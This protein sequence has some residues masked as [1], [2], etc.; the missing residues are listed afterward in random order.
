M[1]GEVLNRGNEVF[2]ETI[3][4]PSP[5]IYRVHVS[6][7]KSDSNVIN[8]AVAVFHDVTDARNFAQMR[9][10]FVGNVSHELRTPL[11]SIKGFVETLLDGAMENS[12]T[13]RRFLKHHRCGKDGKP[14]YRRLVKL[15]AIESLRN[16]GTEQFAW[17][18][19]AWS[20]EYVGGAKTK[21]T[22]VSSLSQ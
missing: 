6:A 15:S 10:E 21:I 12:V 22:Y 20:N 3:V 14:P 17:C 1:V 8:G 7:I 2:T 13:C 5:Q 9:S 18:F 16:C 11:T 19:P 4:N